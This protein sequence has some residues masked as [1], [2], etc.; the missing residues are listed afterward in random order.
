VDVEYAVRDGARIAYEVFGSGP[1]DLAV[2]HGGRFPIDLMWDLPQLAE[3]MDTLGTV[4]R[5]IAFDGRGHGASD[6]LPTTD[7]AAG[8]ESAAADLLAVL[9]AAR[10]DRVSL[11]DLSHGVMPPFLAA[12]YPERVRSM[13]LVH[14]RTSFPELRGFSMEQR[15]NI[16]QTLSTP[17]GLRSENP[18]VA[19]DPVLQRWWG[20]ARRLESSPEETARQMEWASQI[21]TES[22]LDHVRVPALVLHRQ[23]SRWDMETSRANAARIANARFV[24]VPGNDSDVFL[25]DTASVLAEITAF[26]AQEDS[27]PAGDERPLATV[28]FTDIVS[29]TAR[30]AAVGDQ[31][32]RRVLDEHDSTIDTTVTGYRGNVIKNLGDGMLATFDGPARAVR[33]AAAIRDAFAERGIAIRAGLHTGEIELRH[34]DVAGITVHIASRVSALAGPGEILVSRTVVDLTGGSGIT[35]DARGDYELKGVPGEWAIFAAHA[36]ATPTL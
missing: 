27:A 14:L 26:L 12:T 3:F 9:D 7:G 22:V 16:A 18:R 23:G 10:S 24:V 21:D 20:R 31:E 25:G 36:P 33:C 32:W 1:I 17:R 35:Y 34:R 30:L 6:P 8:V 5:V 15:K 19:H 4:A 28:L 13:I 11:L 2:L 29:S